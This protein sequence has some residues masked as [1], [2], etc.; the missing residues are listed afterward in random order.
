[1][2]EKKKNGKMM[3]YSGQSLVRCGNVLYLGD[4]NASHFAM[5]QIISVEKVDDLEVPQKVAVQ[6]VANDPNL[7]LKDKIVKRAMKH[8]LYNAMNIANVWLQ[9]YTQS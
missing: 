4:M 2:A 5:M 6:L 9:Q 1:M 3:S 7:A 8:R